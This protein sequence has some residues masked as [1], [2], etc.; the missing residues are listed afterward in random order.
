MDRG[1]TCPHCQSQHRPYTREAR[2]A[3]FEE[4]VEIVAAEFSS[5]LKIDDVARRVS[6]SPRQ[7]QRVFSD[8]GGT[9]FRSHL[10]RVRMAHAAELLRNTGLPVKEVGRRVGYGDASQFTKAF[11][12]AYGVSPSESRAR[13]TRRVGPSPT[14]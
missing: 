11:K 2:Q 13:R 4:A 14:S 9:G 1:D 6:V 8:V 7:L 5:P 10:R 3:V 12:R